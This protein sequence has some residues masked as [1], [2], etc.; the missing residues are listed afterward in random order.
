MQQI[1]EQW[2]LLVC[3]N[4]I[5]KNVMDLKRRGLNWYSGYLHN[6]NLLWNNKTLSKNINKNIFVITYPVLECMRYAP[7]IYARI[8]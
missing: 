5:I 4:G 1:Y 3:P 7:Y 6:Y 8:S 2:T